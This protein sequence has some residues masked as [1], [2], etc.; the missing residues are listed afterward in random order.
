MMP[1]FLLLLVLFPLPALAFGPVAHVDMGLEV[2]AQAAGLGVG[3]LLARYATDFLRGILAADR[4]LAKTVVPYKLHTHNWERS[5]HMYR[6]AK[7]DAE[8]AFFLG[9]LCH[10]AADWVAHAYFVPLRLVESYKA[11][12]AGHVYWELR[13]DVLARQTCDPAVLKTL[14]MNERAHRKFLA[15]VVP[16]PVLGS[17]LHVRITGWAIALQRVRAYRVATDFVHRESHLVLP[18]AQYDEV[19]RLAIEAQLSVL[20]RLEDAPVVQMDPRGGRPAAV[21]VRLRRY[22]RRLARLPETRAREQEVE[23]VMRQA[24]SY[25]KAV[26]LAGVKGRPMRA[27]EPAT[28]SLALLSRAAQK[29]TGQRSLK[30][31]AAP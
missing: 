2:M 26:T 24:R 11:R 8:R 9:W 12:M 29:K 27:R 1:F 5:F 22:L 10:L 20:R 19:R 13:Y 14:G 6:S 23:R 31:R 16:G 28:G 15:R 7:S 4:E 3:A 21:A 18:A 17:Y 30:S 25:F